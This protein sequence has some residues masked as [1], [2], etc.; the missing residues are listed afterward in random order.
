MSNVSEYT[1]D[2]LKVTLLFICTETTT[3]TGSRIRSL[4]KSHFQLQNYFPHGHH[5]WPW[6]FTTNEL[7]LSFHMLTAVLSRPERDY[8]RIS[9]LAK[10]ITHCICLRPLCS[11][12]K[13]SADVDEHHGMQKFNK[14]PHHCWHNAGIILLDCSSAVFCNK[15]KCIDY[16]RE[17][18]IF[19]AISSVSDVVGPK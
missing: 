15:I 17:N 8:L 11:L 9:P 10:C 4:N 1:R 16:W 14:T 13:R 2:A 7:E 18:I 6:I 5:Y 3:E 19:T 12:R